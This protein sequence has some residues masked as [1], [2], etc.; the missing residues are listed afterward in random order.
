MIRLKFFLTVVGLLFSVSLFADTVKV[1]GKITDDSGVAIEGVT[2]FV[3]SNPTNGTSSL[4]DGY[5]S[6]SVNSGETLVFSFIGYVTK[7]I[8]V[9]DKTVINVVLSEESIGLEELMVVGYGSQS[10]RTITSAITKVSGSELANQPINSVGDGLK[11]KVAGARIYTTNNTPGAEPTILIRGG[12]SIDGSN[13]PLILV[14]GIERDLSGINPNDIESMEVLKDAASSAIYGSRASNGVVLVT[15]KKGAR[16]V[17]PQVTFEVSY[18]LEN[19]ERNM[20]YLNSEEAITLMRKRLSQGPHPNYLTANNYAYSSGNTAE[21]KY[22]TRKLADGEAVPAGY[23]K[24]EDPIN[25]GEYLIFQDNNWVDETYKTALWQ[26]YYIG[27]TG[28]SENIKYL[29]SIGYTDDEGVAIGTN[30]SRFSARANMDIQ[31]FERL[32]IKAGVDFNQNK[33]N[34]YESQYKVIT[35]GMMTPTTQKIYYDAGEWAG[36]PTPGYNASSP[37]PVFYSYYNDTDQKVNKL[38][39]NG[40]LEYK[41]IDGLK[42]VGQA[43]F[44]TSNATGDY[45]TRANIFNGSRP[46]SSNLTDE[47]RQKLETYFSYNKTFNNKHSFSAVAGYSYQRYKYKYLN[48][49]AKD[50]ASDKIPTLNAGPTKT[51]AT[52]TMNEE[53]MIGYFGRFM[54]D[55]QKKYMIMFTFREDGSSKFASGNKWGFF[56]GA[57]A[58]WVISE[59]KFFNVKAINNLKLRVSYGQTGNN[60][61]GYYDALGKYAIGTKYNG[62]ASVV[63]STM[64]NKGLTWETSTQLDAGFD[65]GLWENRVQITADYFRKVTDNLI[66]SK[67]LPNTSGF[68]SILTNLGKVRFAGFDIDITTQNIS[69]KNFSWSTKLVWSYVENKVLK[70]PDNGR[71]KNRIGGYTVKMA[72]GSTIEFGG[73]AEGE[74]LGRFYGYKTDYIITTQEQANNAR[75]DSQS[76]GWDWTKKNYVTGDKN[77]SIGK[78]A[79]GDYEWMDLNG[80]GIINGSDMYYLGNTLPKHTGGL[81]NT[82]T[83]KNLTLNIYLDWALGHSISN[84]LLQRQMCNFFGNNTSLPTEI[85]KAWDPESGQNVADAKYARFGGNDSDELNKN[86][87]PNS[88]VFTTKGDYLCIRDVS[89]QYLLKCPGLKKAKIE[90]IAFTLSG[91][92]LHYFTKVI[93]MSPETGTSNAYSSSFYTYPPIK[94]FSLGVKVTF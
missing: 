2:V 56:P 87:R 67:V 75:Y 15:T 14:D 28:G 26:N 76:R 19:A 65:M 36:T 50:A 44:F 42:F 90:N 30:F 7:E 41:I 38:G 49:A 84:N 20:S 74:P 34:A 22:S 31:A 62:E 3:K 79:I 92:N 69:H 4:E 59:E 58:G 61:V 10:K 45:F 32:T 83:Y 39:L 57:S 86:Y 17:G 24:M 68:G 5:Y 33:T 21:S 47:E 37:T 9:T 73:T 77:S 18:A 54:Y 51:D 63:P 81:G 88:N 11:G 29:A 85:K 13:S 60:Y 46:S 91:S 64:P 8:T 25:P 55:Y 1:S 66:T 72:D 78:K 40:T 52:T 27:I 94:R 23:K 71:D 70:L 6:L 53:V 80:D 48:A 82:F 35:R 16:N 12:S 43:S 89:L 93:G